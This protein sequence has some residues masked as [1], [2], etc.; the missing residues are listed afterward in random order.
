MKRT[1]D[2]GGKGVERVTTQTECAGDDTGGDRVRHQA[3]STGSRGLGS[4]HGGVRVG[5]R[6]GLGN[7]DARIADVAKALP[8]VLLHAASQQPADAGR[9]VGRQRGDVGLALEDRRDRFRGRR[10]LE[11]EPPRQ[12][13]VQDTPE[14]PHVRAAV[15]GLAAGLLRAHVGEGPQDHP[16]LPGEAPVASTHRVATRHRPRLWRGRSRA[17]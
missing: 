10:T 14:G 3:A 8:R 7:L 9:R 2:A 11:R 17:P 5:R 16:F 12:H 13:F 15:S 1:T 6:Q 4:V